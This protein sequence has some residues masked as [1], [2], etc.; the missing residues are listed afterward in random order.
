MTIRELI[1]KLTVLSNVPDLSLDSEI[2][3]F[4]SSIYIGQPNKYFI[5]IDPYDDNTA[6]GYLVPLTPKGEN[7]DINTRAKRSN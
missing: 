7:D 1:N 4:N 2:S 3:I 5:M 6:Y